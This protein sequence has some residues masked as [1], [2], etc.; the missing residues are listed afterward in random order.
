MARAKNPRLK[1]ANT[2]VEYTY[3]N[4]QELKRCADDPIYFIRKYVM[5]QH[6]TQGA[7]PFDLYPYQ[8]KMINAYKENRYTVVL[9]ARQTGK[10]V[11]SAAYLLWYAMFHFDKTILIASNK[12]SN[13]MEM[14]LRIRFAYESLPHW[15]KPGILEDGWNK[16]EIGFDNG[17]RIV[18][19]AT[20]EDSGRGMSISLLFLD[21]FA[22]VSPG[23]QDEFW[24]SIAPT[25][26]TGGSCIMTSTPNG[27]MNI[28]AQIWR[29]AQ[30][31][32]NGFYPI[33][34]KWDEPPGRDATFKEEETGRIGERRWSQEYDCQFLS[35]D[36]LLISSIF[37]ANIT[38]VIEKLRPIKIIKDVVFWHEVKKGGTYLVGVDPSTGTGEDYS[39][40]TVFE[41]PSLIQ[42]AEYRS[43]TMSTNDMYS[44]LKNLLIY[45]E[46]LDTMIYF[47]IENNGVGEGIISLFE[48][49]EYPPEN[50]E[51]VSEEGK[52]RRGMTTT[53]RVKMRAC[54][55]LKEMIEKGN[56]HLSSPILL[57][58][59]KSFARARGAYAA[60]AGSTDDC[61]AATLI[62]VR[63]ME[64]IASYDQA[65][66]DKLYS[67]EFEQ[68]SSD[69]YDGYGDY[70]ENDV[71]LPMSF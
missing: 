30:V 13:A 47:S 17:S 7:V 32:A 2:E 22:F 33:E 68:W 25:L 6:P 12:N 44:V 23:I 62:V 35:S 28:Y 21:E 26:S 54:V 11:C 36:A 65:A 71:G 4:I 31:R 14:I 49:D 66:F 53:S 50:A 24:T 39:V 51:F 45:L 63:L 55:N 70:D 56:L 48:A 46:T 69:D 58:E 37:L 57:A 15:L 34:V 16:H 40:I 59:L 20:S 8:E 1:R 27:D 10:S 19:T 64:E 67:A 52:D 61:V 43:N 29:G 5:I 60:Q 9:S 18:S 38:P 3:D 41:F 42:V